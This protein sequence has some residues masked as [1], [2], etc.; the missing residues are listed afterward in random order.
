[1]QL[2]KELQFKL[3]AHQY[4]RKL[5]YSP[6]DRQKSCWGRGDFRSH[7][8]QERV[9]VTGARILSFDL[10]DLSYAPEI[11]QVMLVRQQAEA[12]IDARKLIVQ[13]CES[14]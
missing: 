7:V 8:L 4:E 2:S 6:P 10:I 13:V 3:Q 9:E 14:Q 11:A 1:M 12:F 5:I